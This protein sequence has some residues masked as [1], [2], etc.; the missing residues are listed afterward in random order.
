VSA[1]DYLR[2]R[3]IVSDEIKRHTQLQP[4]T[5]RRVA[6]AFLSNGWLDVKQIIKDHDEKE[7]E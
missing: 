2:A 7:P 4:D 1:A 6:E 3:N 5:R